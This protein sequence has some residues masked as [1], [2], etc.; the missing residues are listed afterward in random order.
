[1]TW[2]ADVIYTIKT[3]AGEENLIP[4]ALD[5]IEAAPR[6]TGKDIEGFG[7][8]FQERKILYSIRNIQEAL[9]KLRKDSP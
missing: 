1:M 6:V 9:D 5:I 8:K 7:M 4:C 3:N 2:I